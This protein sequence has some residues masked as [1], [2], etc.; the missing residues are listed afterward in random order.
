M[1]T[2]SILI[3]DSGA[4][5]LSVA[6]EIRKQLPGARYIYFAD[7]EYYPYGLKSESE[8]LLRVCRIVDL[9]TT[10]FAIDIAVIACNTASTAV[11]DTLRSRFTIPFVGV[12][13]A[14][15][16]AARMTKTGAI[17]V[18][19][20]TGTV[21]RNYTLAL[22]NEFAGDRSV[23][24]Y[25]SPTLVEIAEA[26]LRGTIP[27]SSIISQEMAGLLMQAQPGEIDTVVL[28]CTHFPLLKREL[29]ECALSVS[30]WVDSGEAIARRV[31]HLV[32]RLGLGVS[33]TSTLSHIL[34][35]SFSSGAYDP[36]ALNEYLGP[37]K[38]DMVEL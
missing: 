30:Y 6:G 24:L 5:G 9:V 35:T 28:A 38:M 7:T 13:P 1:Y 23:Y 8:L 19:A 11:L 32:N 12:V 34:M 10:S 21:S 18:L 37:Y 26:K 29:A 14:V 25:G 36:S 16:P 4:G 33:M 17:G 27:D 3:L 31:E 20:T 2:P 15:K 22:I